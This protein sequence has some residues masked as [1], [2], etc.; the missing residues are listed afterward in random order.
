MTKRALLAGIVGAV[1]MYI[2]I[3]IAH[4]LL[5][6]GEA[7]IQQISNEQALLTQMNSTITAPGLY[8]F[9][10]LAPGGDQA[11]Y[12]RKIESGPSGLMMYFP[13][14]SFNFG[15][16]LAIEFITEL[17]QILLTTYL[18]TLT[19]IVALGGRVAFFA[20]AGL[21]AAIT[22]NVSY[23]N[24]YGFPLSY[25]ASYMFTIWF[26]FVCAGIVVALVLGKKSA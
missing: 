18:L 15:T 17:V 2:W 5:P 20:V 4:M 14:R 7:G 12:Q 6:L 10:N 8:M 1:G 9:P 23:W 16:S 11:E 24:W 26:G 3:F 19:G 13:K 22:T 21:L 25:S